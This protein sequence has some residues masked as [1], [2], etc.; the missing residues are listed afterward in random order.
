MAK[1]T[2]LGH[3]G[4]ELPASM[5]KSLTGIIDLLMDICVGLSCKQ[6]SAN[7]KS[8]DEAVFDLR[9]PQKDGVQIDSLSSILW[10]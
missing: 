10:P 8:A 7:M 3:E 1:L 9:R 5:S 6:F 2:I 4:T